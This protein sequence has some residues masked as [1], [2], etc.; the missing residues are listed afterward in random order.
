[1]AVLL[2]IEYIYLYSVR[3][4]RGTC[5]FGAH[6][7]LCWLSLYEKYWRWQRK[8]PCPYLQLPDQHLRPYFLYLPHQGHS[9]SHLLLQ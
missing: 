1:M 6:I 4:N 9:L 2:Q 8:H 3:K 7:N 5:G